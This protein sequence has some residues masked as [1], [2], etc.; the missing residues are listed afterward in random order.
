MFSIQTILT[1]PIQSRSDHTD[2]FDRVLF[3]QQTH[4]GC[5]PNYGLTS[6]RPFKFRSHSTG[7]SK[8]EHSF[9]CSVFRFSIQN[10]VSFQ[11]RPFKIQSILLHAIQIFG[12]Q[13]S[14]H[15]DLRK[16]LLSRLPNFG[17]IQQTIQ[18]LS[19]LL[20]VQY[21]GHFDQHSNSSTKSVF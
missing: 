4:N 18:N 9:T 21:S 14:D 2:H 16:V 19:I 17:L 8:S 12:V 7:H 1:I 11:N 3:I 10:T 15:F 20:H 6:N 5:D 13:Y